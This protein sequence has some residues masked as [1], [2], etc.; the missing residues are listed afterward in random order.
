GL[1][2]SLGAVNLGQ[3]FPDDPGPEAIRE[4][5]AEAVL[6]GYNQYPPMRGLPELRR[7]WEGDQGPVPTL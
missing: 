7:A 2:R 6:H 3:G 1:A 4:K 5:A